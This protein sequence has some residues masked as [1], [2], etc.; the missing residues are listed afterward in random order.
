MNQEVMSIKAEISK[1]AIVFHPGKT[2]SEKLSE[3]GMSIKEFAV[4]TSKPEK[5]IIAVIGGKS[6]ITTE[7]AVSFEN[8]TQIPASFWLRKQQSY[9]E[10]V[11][12]K[13]REVAAAA[14]ADWMR[15]FPVAE[16]IKRG[17][18]QS[19]TSIEEKVYSL[20]SFF[21]ISTEKAWNDYYINQELKVAFRIS[22]VHAKDPHAMS[23]WLRRGEIQASNVNLDVPYNDRLL[24][25]MLPRMKQLMV[26]DTTDFY[27]VLQQLCADCGIKLVS[28]EC[29]PKAPISGATRWIK[30][31][32]IIQ[33]SNRYKRY[34]I[35]WFN[36]FHEIGHILL[37]GK[38]DIFLEKAGCFDQD[39]L[40]EQEAD[41][42]ASNLMLSQSEE[43]SIIDSQDYSVENIK[44]TAIKYGTHPA[45]IV[46]R[47]Q[48]RGVIDYWQDQSLLKSVNI[49]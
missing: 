18:I 8:V 29:L 13:K 42:F 30:D 20:F 11:E 45:V 35:F 5:T 16:M 1:L 19:A 3:M 24:K 22:L 49:N 14:S 41:K 12:R 38:K 4:R 34:D 31:V 48:H 32:P 46:G 37:H 40:K 33:L 26:D 23:S 36:F 27:S 6:S 17:W 10:Y 7:M 9:D 15:K 47:L 44:R 28:T 39:I 43:Q 25:S 2:L 21:A